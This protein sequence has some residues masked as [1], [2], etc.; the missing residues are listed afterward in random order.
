[1]IPL[2]WEWENV[3]IDKVN[4]TFPVRMTSFNTLSTIL[5]R[6]NNSFVDEDTWIRLNPYSGNV[7]D[8]DVGAEVNSYYTPVEG[9]DWHKIN[10]FG[11]NKK[12]EGFVLKYNWSP[13]DNTTVF[14]GSSATVGQGL[15]P[16]PL[17]PGLFE[18]LMLRRALVA[19]DLA[20]LDGVINYIIDWEIGD[21]TVVNNKMPNQPR[22]EKK[23]ADGSVAEKSTIQLVK[24]MITQDNRA[25]VMQLFHPYYVK[26]NIKTPDVTSLVSAEKYIQSSIE[27][28]NAFGIFLPPSNQSS[29]FQ[30]INISNFEQMLDNIRLFHIRRFWEMLATEIIKRNEGKLTNIPNMSFN[31]LNTQDAAFRSALLEIAKIGR[32]STETLLQACKRDK[33][34]EI[35]RIAQENMSGEKELMDKN[36]PVSYKQSVVDKDGGEK[37]VSRPG[38]NEGG[39]P[40]KTDDSKKVAKDKKDKEAD[41]K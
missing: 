41:I 38:T 33:N 22:P 17:F 35:T 3:T 31:P 32:L 11:K 36:V 24:E 6:K 13:S 27:I 16:S 26:L 5:E 19:S 10:R 20:I 40:K 14:S 28:F 21:N 18:V 37:D 25:N 34:T 8:A 4:Y 2:E 15:Y 1:M 7:S 9:R 30:S 39:R 23:N 29:N 12:S